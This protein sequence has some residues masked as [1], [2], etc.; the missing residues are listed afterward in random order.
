MG[1][2]SQLRRAEANAQ[3]D[4]LL[5]AVHEAATRLHETTPPLVDLINHA[6]KDP[7]LDEGTK[8][9]ARYAWE[10]G[11]HG[12]AIQLQ[13]ALNLNDPNRT[14]F[15]LEKPL[16]T[17]LDMRGEEL[18]TLLGKQSDMRLFI[19]NQ[20]RAKTLRTNSDYM[21]VW[22]HIYEGVKSDSPFDIWWL[23]YATPIIAESHFHPYDEGTLNRLAK[24]RADAEEMLKTLP[25]H[26]Q[27]T[28]LVKRLLEQ[29][30]IQEQVAKDL[31]RE[32]VDIKAER[33]KLIGMLWDQ[34]ALWMASLI[35]LATAQGFRADE[36]WKVMTAEDRAANRKFLNLMHP[37]ANPHLKHKPS[38]ET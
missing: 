4:N 10:W 35:N 6:M 18:T 5:S 13:M 1:Q 28:A 19:L 22:Y 17:L 14:A 2:N 27:V 31:A 32:Q 20:L 34:H 33:E 12:T 36:S 7:A 15:R 24:V 29:V 26:L 3:R 23:D 11:V 8:Q 9:R 25:K 37:I 30:D 21:S 38:A 16:R